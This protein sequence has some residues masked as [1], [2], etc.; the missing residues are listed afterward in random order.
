[1]AFH[2]LLWVVVLLYRRNMAVQVRS[3]SRWVYF[4]GGGFVGCLVGV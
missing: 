3:R 1:M 4:G 2:A